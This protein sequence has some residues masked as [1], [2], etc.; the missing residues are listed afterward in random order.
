MATKLW[1]AMAFCQEHVVQEHGKMPSVLS[2]LPRFQAYSGQG[3]RLP[4][5]VLQYNIQSNLAFEMVDWGLNVIKS[6][7]FSCQS[8]SIYP[9]GMMSQNMNSQ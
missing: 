4:F 2:G 6:L 3:T 7:C 1:R 9:D 5:R 8:Y